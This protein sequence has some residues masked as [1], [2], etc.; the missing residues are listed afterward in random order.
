M[1]MGKL[2]F[3]K[4]DGA[5]NAFVVVDFCRSSFP[6]ASGGLRRTGVISDS[7]SN[8]ARFL[9]KR[10][11]S[12]DADG[13][14]VLEKSKKADFRMRIFNADGSEAEMCGNGMRCAT[15]YFGK[16]GKVRIE[17]IAGM[18]EA[19]IT[20][21]D[22][23]RIKMEGPRDLKLDIPIAAND[24]KIK[25]N[26]IDS[27]V[28]HVVIFVQGLDKVDVG[29][30]G[31]A[32]RYHERFKPRGANV[33]FVEVIDDKN[34]RMRTYERGVEG[35]TLACGTGAVASAIISNRQ[36][37]TSNKVNVHVKGGVLKVYFENKKGRIEDVFLEGEAKEVYKGE[38]EYV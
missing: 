36:Q 19:E 18:Y 22:K 8:L 23:V 12:L 37:A 32:V 2:K 33:D 26:Y 29:S 17:T 31:Q 16:K 25:V 38:V 15:L 13:L 9:C 4:M 11:A 24:R 28:P 7:L 1:K 3:T 5:G 14:L 27:G 10:K 21:K 6:S 35:E 34:I 30:I 20:G